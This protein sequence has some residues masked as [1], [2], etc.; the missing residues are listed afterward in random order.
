MLP[1]S[2]A[3]II[4]TMFTVESVPLNV[5]KPDRVAA[6][7]RD[8]IKMLLI[9]QKPYDIRERLI[10]YMYRLHASHCTRKLG[11]NLTRNQI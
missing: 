6:D 8:L 4:I 3:S 10:K 9:L 7:E 5:M 11:E 1:W 2:T